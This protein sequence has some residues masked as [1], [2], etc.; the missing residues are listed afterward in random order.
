M[1]ASAGVA[2]GTI[3]R[4]FRCYGTVNEQAHIC[5]RTFVSFQGQLHFFFEFRFNERNSLK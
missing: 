3:I 1:G 4:K 2:P 5:R